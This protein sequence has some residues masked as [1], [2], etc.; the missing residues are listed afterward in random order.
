MAFHKTKAYNYDIQI[1]AM[2]N[3]HPQFKVKKK[4]KSEF[5]FIGDLQVKPEF[6]VYTVSIR[7][8]GSSTPLVKVLS[9]K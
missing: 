2:R 6:P 9:P 7:Y 1:W 5:E 4:S 8:R 3:R